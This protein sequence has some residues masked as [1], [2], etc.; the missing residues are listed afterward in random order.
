MQEAIYL[1]TDSVSK[2]WRQLA[3]KL[4]LS[5]SEVAAIEAK[6][7][8]ARTREKC[9]M[10]LYKW[11]SMVVLQEY[12]VASIML[13]LRECRLTDVAG[14]IQ[15]P[16]RSLKLILKGERFSYLFIHG[17]CYILIFFPQFFSADLQEFS[18]SGKILRPQR[19]R[20]KGRSI[21]YNLNFLIK[22]PSSAW[23]HK[24]LL[25][26]YNIYIPLCAAHYL[27]TNATIIQ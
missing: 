9:M 26:L 24:C 25:Y 1:V 19:S 11:R 3:L 27:T 22:S 14:L 7:P 2:Y 18:Q 12:K 15:I 23:F 17:K 13:A 20:H 8:D 10:A 21:K 16:L 6:H 5:K 4:R